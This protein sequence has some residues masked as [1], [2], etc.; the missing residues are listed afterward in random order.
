MHKQILVFLFVTLISHMVSAEVTCDNGK[1]FIGRGTPYPYGTQESFFTT[2]D[3]KI[4]KYIGHALGV[5]GS[6]LQ[7]KFKK[8]EGGFDYLKDDWIKKIPGHSVVLKD[9]GPASNNSRTV[10][11]SVRK[12]PLVGC[13]EYRI[14]SGCYAGDDYCARECVSKI[15]IPEQVYYKK[16]IFCQENE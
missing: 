10:E 14:V 4:L 1:I 5:R 16:K 11:L 8:I 7:T 12:N 2:T 13:L 6:L 15:N 3:Q 9:L